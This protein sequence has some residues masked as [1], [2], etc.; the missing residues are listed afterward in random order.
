MSVY[1]VWAERRQVNLHLDPDFVLS[2]RVEDLG[3]PNAL[4]NTARISID[5]IQNLW[6]SPGPITIKE[7]LDEEYPM[8]LTTVS[9]DLN[10]MLCY[11][12]RQCLYF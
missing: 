4:S 5:I 3:D 12:T 6:V 2:V 7:N 9:L 11:G 10:T 1:F 8:Y